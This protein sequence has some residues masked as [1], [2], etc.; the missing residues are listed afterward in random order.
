MKYK[1]IMLGAICF[2]AL[3]TYASEDNL[4]AEDFNE[5]NIYTSDENNLSAS[6]PLDD[7]V[8]S[9]DNDHS[10][11]QEEEK[12]LQQWIISGFNEIKDKT[13]NLF[14]DIS[15]TF[16]IDNLSS[17]AQEQQTTPLSLLSLNDLQDREDIIAD[18]QEDMNVFIAVDD[19]AVLTPYLLSYLYNYFKYMLPEE[20]TSSGRVR[21]RIPYYLHARSRDHYPMVEVNGENIYVY[22]NASKNIITRK[23]HE[24]LEGVDTSRA[25]E[26]QVTF[27]YSNELYHQLNQ[28]FLSSE[29]I[30]DF[31]YENF[32]I[33]L[34]LDSEN[35]LSRFTQEFTKEELLLIL[36]TLIDIP[37][38]IRNTMNLTHIVRMPAYNLKAAGVYYPAFTSILIYGSASD[39][40]QEVLLHELAHA[41]DGMKIWTGLPL[42][43]RSSY[44]D[45]SWGEKNNPLYNS[46]FV[47]DYGLENVHEDFS[48]HFTA[49]IHSPR[50]LMSTAPKKYK[51]LKEH[52][53]INTEYATGP[54]MDNL[55]IFVDSDLEDITPPHFS[56]NFD[57]RVSQ[58]T[59]KS[60]NYLTFR[61]EIDGL[62]D[63]LSGIKKIELKFVQSYFFSLR[64]SYVHLI[65]GSP[66]P[67]KD[68]ISQGA[69]C[70][71]VVPVCSFFDSNKPGK[72]IF[73][74]SLGKDIYEP[75]TYTLEKITV[76]DLSLNKRSFHSV[77]GEPPQIFIPGTAPPE[78]EEREENSI[79]VSNM[80][81]IQQE[82][83]T[84]DTLRYLMTPVKPNINRIYVWLKGEDTKRILRYDLDTNYFED[85]YEDFE[86]FSGFSVPQEPGFYTVPV[87]IP[88]EFDSEQYN[89]HKM[90][91]QS[92]TYDTRVLC[93]NTDF[94]SLAHQSC[95]GIMHTST[96]SLSE[97]MYTPKPVVEDIQLS[98][99]NQIKNSRGG[100]IAIKVSIPITGLFNKDSWGE[101]YLRTPLD[102][103]LSPISEEY[104]ESDEG[105]VLSAQFDLPPHHAEGFY[106]LSHVSLNTM[107]EN[108]DKL[109]HSYYNVSSLKLSSNNN[110]SERMMQRTLTIQVPSFEEGQAENMDY[111]GSSF[112]IGV[113]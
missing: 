75:G 10:S 81:W 6:N 71:E 9:E 61:V 112:Q 21:I 37:P 36:K 53:F 101:I 104:I 103:K 12:N 29:D 92:P 58:E 68:I 64:R 98:I 3:S 110:F 107:H 80:H 47:S 15:S 95:P 96:S 24:T 45:L 89:L 77:N 14:E 55:E 8:L 105:W 48:E 23:F 66:A 93:T 85:I 90:I 33:S 19:P 63:D 57:I 11:S 91:Y 74:N 99:V 25:S 2:L 87:V 34:E 83:K 43:A 72:Y 40:F 38:H 67:F 84:G 78:E 16:F 22:K 70:K 31:I 41:L 82:T 65:G 62:F 46:E 30:E 4:P 86:S 35:P 76:T 42:K 28:A 108:I 5:T 109:Y 100:N 1:I 51:W 106:F 7:D 27:E 111:S 52:V 97:E 69:E 49:Y 13:T 32:N 56:D 17:E 88:A 20:P 79:V 113:E 39:N 94:H 26:I 18:L 59:K 102:V 60:E 50:R 54:V 44:K 73:M